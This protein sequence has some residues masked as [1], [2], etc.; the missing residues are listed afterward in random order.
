GK[1]S[2]DFAHEPPMITLRSLGPLFGLLGARAY[3]PTAAV[4]CLGFVERTAFA[5]VAFDLARERSLRGLVL[6]LA[7]AGVLVVR[8]VVAALLV[9][10]VRVSLWTGIARALFGGDL[11]AAA[12]L[13]DADAEVAVFD[14][15]GYAERLLAERVPAFVGD[16]LAALVLSL[17]VIATEPTR[18]V[19]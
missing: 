6:A 15:L 13:R 7:V 9:R 2:R 4:A 12:P 11:L 14:G 17:Y 10:R 19:L 5:L 18:V 1:R 3:A 16:A 8:S